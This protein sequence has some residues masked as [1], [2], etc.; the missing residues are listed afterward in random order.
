MA[1]ISFALAESAKSNAGL[2]GLNETL[3]PRGRLPVVA[4]VL[5]LQLHV[6]SGAREAIRF[7][8]LYIAYYVESRSVASRR[9]QFAR[10]GR[11]L[12]NAT[13]EQ[14]PASDASRRP[15]EQRAISAFLPLGAGVWQT[16]G[17]SLESGTSNAPL[18]LRLGLSSRPEH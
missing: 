16:T 5:A 9:V 12:R 13:S 6:Q 1:Q 8:F 18:A 7:S 10:L 15:R 17:K 3:S 4:T 11:S 2:A 14:P